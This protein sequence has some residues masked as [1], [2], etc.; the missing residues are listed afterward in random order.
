MFAA[1]PSSGRGTSSPARAA[2]ERRGRRAQLQRRVEPIVEVTYDEL[3]I[4]RQKLFTPQLLR[5]NNQD[6]TMMSR[7]QA[8]LRNF[9]N[10]AGLTL[11]AVDDNDDNAEALAAVL[12]AG[13]AD[14]FHARAAAAAL[15]Y[16]DT[17][18]RIDAIVADL[19]M[20]RSGLELLKK[21]RAHPRRWRMPVI[22]VTGYYQ[23]YAG[24]TGF[25][26]FFHKPVNFDRLCA[27]ISALVNRRRNSI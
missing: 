16:L 22:A 3:M 4:A 2:L 11:L 23:E 5:A 18:P 7:A 12:R 13:S 25:D 9:P 17:A 1:G 27:T 8:N 26:A 21:V 6:V 15:A 20:R 14:V 10:L 19:A 24:V